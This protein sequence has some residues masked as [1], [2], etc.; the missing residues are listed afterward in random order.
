MKN[1]DLKDKKV[2]G[3]LVI[4]GAIIGLTFLYINLFGSPTTGDNRND[5]K[6]Q[7]GEAASFLNFNVPTI[8]DTI[9]NDNLSSLYE[10]ARTDSVTNARLNEE[11]M[12]YRTPSIGSKPYSSSSSESF[13]NSEFES[14]RSSAIKNSHST[15]GTSDMWS[16][17]PSVDVGYSDMGNV[18]NTPAKSNKSKN[19]SKSTEEIITRNEVRDIEIPE[20]PTYANNQNPLPN[21]KT[22][23]ERLQDAIAKKYGESEGKSISVKGQIFGEQMIGSQNNSVR[24]ILSE[25]LVL[26]GTTIGTD[27][28]IYGIANVSGNNVSITIPNISYKG[29]NFPVNLKVFDYRT[30]QLGIPINLDNI[31]GVI[32]ERGESTASSEIS[33]YGGRVGS[34]LTSVLSGRNKNAK[35]QLNSG[36]QIYLKTDT[37]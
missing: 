2:K 5:K 7:T 36:H 3:A 13:S 6:F 20:M 17:K 26:N 28:N 22:K 35:I 33:R 30:G 24:I 34:I 32:S 23:E 8:K 16:S 19:K 29:K 27:A 37:K 12:S 31:V 15:Y 25:K 4:V 18:I 10:K 9:K 1:L 14:M 11:A 21:V